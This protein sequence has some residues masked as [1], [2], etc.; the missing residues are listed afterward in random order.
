MNQLRAAASVR[1]A[2]GT[3]RFD[4]PGDS[5]LLARV[6][7]LYDA[8]ERYVAGEAPREELATAVEGARKEAASTFVWDVD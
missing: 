2:L 7:E 6:L 4:G 1:E 3:L 8:A 5:E